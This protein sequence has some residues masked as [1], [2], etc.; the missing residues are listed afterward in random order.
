MSSKKSIA[1]AS[2]LGSFSGLVIFSAGIAIVIYLLLR[3]QQKRLDSSL[4]ELNKMIGRVKET[5]PFLITD[6]TRR[7]EY[8]KMV[9]EAILP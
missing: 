6:E 9:D 7:Q 8:I 4:D 2:G 1:I 5:L 3:P